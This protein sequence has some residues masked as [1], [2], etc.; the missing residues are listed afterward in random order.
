M[1]HLHFPIAILV[2]E[3]G[4]IVGAA[5]D[6]PKVVTRLPTAIWRKPSRSSKKFPAMFPAR[7]PLWANSAR[8]PRHKS[9]AW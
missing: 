2:H 1:K 4:L 7:K 8:S 9:R 3:S 6:Y 5:N